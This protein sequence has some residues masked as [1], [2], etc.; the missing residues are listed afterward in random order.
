MDD[1]PHKTLLRV[2]DKTNV[3]S[4]AN[5]KC[6][7]VF[8]VQPE[9]GTEAVTTATLPEPLPDNEGSTLFKSARARALA[10]NVPLD[11][12]IEE[13]Q[14]GKLP[15]DEFREFVNRLGYSAMDADTIVAAAKAPAQE[16]L[17]T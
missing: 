10:L 16:G 11:G 9:P 13:F 6:G 5:K 3:Y 1:C 17:E 4:C 7:N 15:V 14:A 8:L 12:A 2:V